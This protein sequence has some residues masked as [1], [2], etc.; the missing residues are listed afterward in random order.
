MLLKEP[1]V[2]SFSIQ[3]LGFHSAS[4][5]FI[6]TQVLYLIVTRAKNSEKGHS[7]LL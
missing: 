3:N 7:D 1:S 4:I 5:I 2:I 6:S